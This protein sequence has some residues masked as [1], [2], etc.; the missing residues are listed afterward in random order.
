MDSKQAKAQTIAL[1]EK[2]SLLAQQVYEVVHLRAARQ[3]IDRSF[4]VIVQHIK[5][6][7]QSGNIRIGVV[8]GEEEHD[9]SLLKEIFEQGGFS[10]SV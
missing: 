5:T 8:C 2:H 3:I 4:D 1:Y 9:H 6:Y 7:S 10:V